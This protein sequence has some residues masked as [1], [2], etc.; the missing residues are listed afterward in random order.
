M[1]SVEPVIGPNLLSALA[2]LGFGLSL[3]IA[4]GAQNAL[5]LRQG[6]RREHVGLVVGIC[7]VSDILLITAG[8]AGVGALIERVDWLVLVIRLLGTAFLLW[9]AAA[10]VKRVVKRESMPVE[11]A[12][13]A[14]ARKVAAAVFAVT[15]LNPHV[16]ID[17]VMLLGSVGN[18]QPHPWIFAVGAAVGS[19]IWFLALGYGA[20]ALRGFFA[21]QRSWQI[22]DSAIAVV[23]IAIA[24][25]LATGH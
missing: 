21:S 10:A 9:Y 2:G 5:V 16:Y 4:I 25:K 24:V 14:P 15:W 23:L 7:A 11:T 3:I 22:L 8:V 12:E 6:L 1:P 20:R 18:A 13:P 17:T 19:V